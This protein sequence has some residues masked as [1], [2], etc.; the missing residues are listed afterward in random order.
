LLKPKYLLALFL[1]IFAVSVL[2]LQ[3]LKAPWVDECYSFY[4]VWHDSL[5]EF[6]KSML[7]GI[8]FSPPFYFLF[9]FCIQLVFPSSIEILRIQSL[10]WTVSGLLICFTLSRKSFG[11]T[12]SFIGLLFVVSNSELLL[13]Q[14][15]EARNYSLFF[16]C[17]AWVLYAQGSNMKCPKRLFIFT[18]MAHLCLCQ[19]HYLGIIFSSLVGVSYLFTEKKIFL[20]KRIPSSLYANWAISLFLYFYF[21]SNQKSLLNTWPKPNSFSDLLS[22]YA[23]GM[24]ALLSI[25]PV[26]LIGIIVGNTLKKKDHL[27]KTHNPVLAT[28]ILWYGM[29]FAAWVLSHLTP[30]NLFN[31]RY[32]MPKEVACIFLISFL[33]FSIQSVWVKQIFKKKFSDNVMLLSATTICLL[34]VLLNFKRSS[35]TYGEERNYHHW[36]INKDDLIYED[37]PLVFC[38]DPLFFPNVYDDPEQAFFLVDNNSMKAIYTKFSKR[39]SI[40]TPVELNNLNSFILIAEKNQEFKE[41]TL[42]FRTTLLGEFHKNLSFVC[43]RF[44]KRT[45]SS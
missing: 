6:Y 24:L 28:S 10:F 26:L 22:C 32:F 45:P 7:T 9:N 13:A 18:F 20:L 16:A 43:T 25:I 29:P 30:I 27:P 41:E 14:S 15:L 36:L 35:F 39:I 40:L 1:L 31:A 8:N 5:S 42:N 34:F 33:C 11:T 12:P 2:Y 23:D 4:G 38:G 21:L 17:G 44:D 19:A 37:L 3:S